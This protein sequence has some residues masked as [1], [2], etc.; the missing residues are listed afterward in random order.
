MYTPVMGSCLSM[1]VRAMCS[2]SSGFV[3]P[4]MMS[5]VV[6]MEHEAC[7]MPMSRGKRL[8]GVAL[9]HVHVTGC[10]ESANSSVWLSPL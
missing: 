2:R 7:M 4:V 8:N 6:W 1:T 10:R 3:V 9:D 5:R